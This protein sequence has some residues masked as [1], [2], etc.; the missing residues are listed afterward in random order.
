MEC[1]LNLFLVHFVIT[2]C[3]R[4][5][6]MNTGSLDEPL[7]FVGDIQCSTHSDHKVYLEEKSDDTSINEYL[8]GGNGNIT[9]YTESNQCAHSTHRHGILSK[10]L[11]AAKK[12]GHFI[13]SSKVSGKSK[14]K[15][16]SNLFTK[17]IHK[18]CSTEL[19]NSISDCK[20]VDDETKA[21]SE[22]W[23]AFLQMQDRIQLN[24]LKTQQNLGRL[25]IGGISSSDNDSL[26]EANQS[27]VG[28]DQSDFPIPCAD[29]GIDYISDVDEAADKTG[30]A[31]KDLL[32][33]ESDNVEK[34]DLFRNC[35]VLQENTEFASLVAGVNHL[36]QFRTDSIQS[37]SCEMERDDHPDF[38]VYDKTVP[39][40]TPVDPTGNGEDVCDININP[41]FECSETQSTTFVN[42]DDLLSLDEFLGGPC[43][44][45]NTDIRQEGN[46]D[47]FLG[48]GSAISSNR[49]SL[50]SSPVSSLDQDF[51]TEQ[52][53]DVCDSR[54]VSDLARKLVDDFLQWGSECDEAS[55]QT[56]NPF[57]SDSYGSVSIKPSSFN[58]FVTIRESD[59]L[60]FR[61]HNHLP[62]EN[63]CSANFVVPAKT[64][65]NKQDFSLDAFNCFSKQ[66]LSQPEMESSI[67]KLDENPCTAASVISHITDN[68]KS[69]TEQHD[70]CMDVGITSLPERERDADSIWG[71]TILS[72][73]EILK[74]DNDF[75]PI[76][77][78]Q[79]ITPTNCSAVKCVNP[80]LSASSE[81]IYNLS[82]ETPDDMRSV[83]LTPTDELDA[84]CSQMSDVNVDC[85]PI[86]L[87]DSHSITS[88]DSQSEMCFNKSALDSET[89]IKSHANLNSSM[90]NVP[91]THIDLLGNRIDVYQNTNEVYSKPVASLLVENESLLH[92]PIAMVDSNDFIE[93]QPHLIDQD[94]DFFCKNNELQKGD[95]LLENIFSLNGV[96]SQE[97]TTSLP[98][99]A[100]T[101]QCLPMNVDDDEGH[102]AYDA[103]LFSVVSTKEQDKNGLYLGHTETCLNSTDLREIIET[104]RMSADLSS[105]DTNIH[106]NNVDQSPESK[107]TNDYQCQDEDEIGSFGFKLKILE[108]PTTSGQPNLV[109]VPCLPPPPKFL[110][111]PLFSRE[112]PFD[113]D[114]HSQQ[115]NFTVKNA[116][117][118]ESQSSS[119]L[120][121]MSSGSSGSYEEEETYDTL[122]SFRPSLDEIFWK[123]MIRQPVKKK[124]AGNRCWKAVCV[125]LEMLK[126]GPV[127]R[128]YDNEN[129]K[130]GHFHELTMQP[131]YS[132]SSLTAQQYDQFG[133]IHTVKIQYIFYRE[134]VGIKPERIAPSLVKKPKAT[135]ALDHAPHVSE[136]LKFGSL[137]I[138]E[139]SSFVWAFEDIMMRL[140]VCREKPFSYA[141]DELQAKCW[142]NMRQLLTK[143]VTF[144]IRKLEYGY[145][146]WHFLQV[147]QNVKSESMTGHVREK[148]L[149]DGM[150]L[151]R[152]RLKTG[153]EL[154]ILNFIVLW[155]WT[156]MKKRAIYS[157]VHWMPVILNSYVFGLDQRRIAN[158]HC[159]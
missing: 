117:V 97:A 132:L 155:T 19:L 39:P 142:M 72:S 78:L 52:E 157:F 93:H 28:I 71:T 100:N 148:K 8:A 56:K 141:K 3:R 82:T 111:P 37:D 51:W 136:L 79:S 48:Q 131:C 151:S 102:N 156:P 84:F 6:D 133:K 36:T 139:I 152:L 34:I 75:L 10:K 104:C 40:P 57:T 27:H 114:D 154:N 45:I 35:G 62:K 13:K 123:L 55:I 158:C 146:Y 26:D 128:L 47:W 24:V 95:E 85:L 149:L 30:D 113:N 119:A 16:S 64:D 144:C 4:Y 118:D 18:S 108:K 41:N 140:D 83:F 59:D 33:L 21:K 31:G 107:I 112:N 110:K 11:K 122:E 143:M 53:N 81:N 61:D 76:C 96:L 38:F 137:N 46:T 20:P 32:D 22:Q 12:I 1:V 116:D 2:E 159:N 145:L 126:Y 88:M 54:A 23:Q 68:F 99:D 42:N 49:S 92:R 87:P 66:D 58:P 77:N 89:N 103:E 153:S 73:H 50:C 121:S 150:T 86:C 15:S 129:G 14:L 109:H 130:G 90:N 135:M 63:I 65:E 91:F 69:E 138:N 101:H 134:R 43:S 7:S 105:K 125:K 70:R 29:H 17:T 9:K 74:F 67:N 44:Q 60:I 115:D 147:C 98:T 94:D 80:F 120:K 124:L 106:E 5:I 25:A 127:L